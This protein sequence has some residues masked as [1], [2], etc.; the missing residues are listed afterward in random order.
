[1]MFY[2]KDL[3]K[4]KTIQGISLMTGLK[5]YISSYLT[6]ICNVSKYGSIASKLS[7]MAKSDGIVFLSIGPF[8]LMTL[9]SSSYQMPDTYMNYIIVQ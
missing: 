4:K 9:M 7:L 3:G 5:S 8:F 2:E 1:M 6:K